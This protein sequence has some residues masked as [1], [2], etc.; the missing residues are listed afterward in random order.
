MKQKREPLL[1]F[2]ACGE[3][4]Y[5]DIHIVVVSQPEETVELLL[6]IMSIMNQDLMTPS[7]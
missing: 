1:T 3:I 5:Y 7:I 2:Q 4:S 6:Y